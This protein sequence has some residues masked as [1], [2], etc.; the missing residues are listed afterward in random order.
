MALLMMV[1]AALAN[2]SVL[3]ALYLRFHTPRI[4]E[5][6]LL[7]YFHVA[8]WF[9]S[10]T[11]T[12]FWL[13]RL[14]H[15]TG[16]YAFARDAQVL[17][18][19]VVVLTLVLGILLLITCTAD[20]ARPVCL[21]YTLFAIALVGGWRLVVRSFCDVHFFQKQIRRG[22]PVTVTRSEKGESVRMLDL[23][24]HLIGLSGSIPAL[25]LQGFVPARNCLRNY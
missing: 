10:A 3:L 16:R 23:A 7:A 2:A 12:I 1:D 25:C 6:D 4:P 11:I 5:P 24:S 19:A 20:Y 8:I 14:Y 9:T 22:G 13:T 15:R 17:I 18:F 21:L